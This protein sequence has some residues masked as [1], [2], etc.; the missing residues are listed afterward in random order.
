MDWKNLH[1]SLIA[2]ADHHQMD[3]D[4][5]DGDHGQSRTTTYRLNEGTRTFYELK[6]TKP[7]LQGG[8]KL[9][10]YSRFSGNLSITLKRT[11]FGRIAIKSTQRLSQDHYGRLEALGRTIGKFR[12]ATTPHHA[13][14]PSELSG[15]PTLRFECTRIDLAAS[16]LT[17]IKELHDELLTLDDKSADQKIEA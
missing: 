13:G 11:L 4:W 17:Q 10:I 14:W 9:R 15:C 3:L 8:S 2:F 6:H 12:W 16:V 7:V 1:N 5:S